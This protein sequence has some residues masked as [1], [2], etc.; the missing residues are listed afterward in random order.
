MYMKTHSYKNT[1]QK[2]SLRLDFRYLLL[3]ILFFSTQYAT[4]Q[5]LT[6]VKVIGG[7]SADC[8]EGNAVQTNYLQ[9]IILSLMDAKQSGASNSA[10]FEI[11]FVECEKDKWVKLKTIKTEFLQQTTD[12]LKQSQ[13]EKTTFENFRVQVQ[14][15]KGKVIQTSLL[16]GKAHF[17]FKVRV[18][19]LDI[20]RDEDSKSKYVDVILLADRKRQNAADFYFEEVNWGRVRLPLGESAAKK[21]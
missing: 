14:D 1:T 17:K 7:F 12:E 9:P 6:N 4:S 20:A 15:T 3:A 8:S 10:D 16:N 13:K 21:K 19:S 2:R 18:N 11:Q 5:E